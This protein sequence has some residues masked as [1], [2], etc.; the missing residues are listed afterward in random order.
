MSDTSPVMHTCNFTEFPLKHYLG[1]ISVIAYGIWLPF[2]NED[3]KIESLIQ[4]QP[5]KAFKLVSMKLILKFK[6]I[7]Y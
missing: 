7:T 6:S 2:S 1:V 4:I 5:Q 3:V